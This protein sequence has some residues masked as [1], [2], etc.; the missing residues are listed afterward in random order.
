MP[1][2]FD[3]LNDR[4]ALFYFFEAPT[5]RQ[6]PE[7][8]GENTPQYRSSYGAVSDRR[9]LGRTLPSIKLILSVFRVKLGPAG[10]PAVIC[11]EGANVV[12]LVKIGGNAIK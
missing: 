7:G 5:E 8:P 4:T 1:S 3:K 12:D 10:E 11:A 9:G 6:R 2:H